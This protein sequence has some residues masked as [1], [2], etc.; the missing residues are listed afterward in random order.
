M[1]RE[2]NQN[3]NKIYTL[4]AASTLKSKWIVELKQKPKQ[5][6]TLYAAANKELHRRENFEA[7]VLSS[8][9]S[10]LPNNPNSDLGFNQ[11]TLLLHINK[12]PQLIGF[13]TKLL[14]DMLIAKPLHLHL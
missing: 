2:Q 9:R 14:C 5:I 6:Y 7:K 1:I 3:Q 10:M 11:I 8:S 4:Y 13:D 12:L